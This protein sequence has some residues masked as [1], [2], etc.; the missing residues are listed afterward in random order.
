[1][2]SAEKMIEAEGYRGPIGKLLAKWALARQALEDG[3]KRNPNI[4]CAGISRGEP[5][6]SVVISVV[7]DTNL[8]IGSVRDRDGGSFYK[9]EG[10]QAN[11]YSTLIIAKLFDSYVDRFFKKDIKMWKLSK[12]TSHALHIDPDS[13]ELQ[14]KF[15]TTYNPEKVI[16]KSCNAYGPG[17]AAIN[18]IL[19]R[20]PAPEIFEKEIK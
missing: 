18:D 7:K 16:E 14:H 9:F 17:K 12:E 19:K 5:N 6:K 20:R 8:K 2:P 11:L 4:S 10:P 13:F 3:I 1:M 15:H